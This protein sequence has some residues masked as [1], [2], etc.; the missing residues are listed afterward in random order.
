MAARPSA[1][2]AGSR[3]ERR[4]RTIAARPPKDGS[5][6]TAVR[7]L[8]AR[9][10]TPLRCADARFA[11]RLLRLTHRERSPV[12]RDGGGETRPSGPRA[13][14]PS[15]DD[16]QP[17]TAPARRVPAHLRLRNGG[18]SIDIGTRRV[19]LRRADAEEL[20]A[21]IAVDECAQ[22]L[23]RF[24]HRHVDD[25]PVVVEARIAVASPSSVC[26][27]QTKPSAASARALTGPSS[28]TKSASSGAS[29]DSRARAM[30]TCA[31]WK[32]LTARVLEPIARVRRHPLGSVRT[33]RRTADFPQAL[34]RGETSLQG[35]VA[36]APVA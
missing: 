16:P 33:A 30:L 22:G 9:G 36:A 17:V 21:C 19:G 28:A 24:P 18:A 6:H 31:S 29:S 12:A 13:T 15:D 32:E 10:P 34:S 27:R 1:A 5:H 25:E 2:V 20:G 35:V 8:P 3:P 23:E 4:P 26:K 11:P 14:T 7:G